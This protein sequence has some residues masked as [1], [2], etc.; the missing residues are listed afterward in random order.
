MIDA[1]EGRGMSATITRP[2]TVPR[3]HNGDR[4]TRAEFERRYEAM[5]D[6]K[7]AELIE[8]VVYMPSPVRWEQHGDQHSTLV[9][10]F[11]HY[12]LLTPGVEVGDNSTTRLDD[13]NE[14]Q[15]DVSLFVSPKMNSQVS[16]DDGYIEGA[17]EL[18]AEIAASTASIDL[19]DKLRAYQ[20]NGVREYLVW[21]VEDEEIDW[22]ILRDGTF[23]RG[24]PDPEGLLKLVAFPGLWLDVPALLRRDQSAA[25]A[26][27]TRGLASPEHAAFVERL[28]VTSPG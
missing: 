18:V 4:L 24:T 16:I 12:R 9:W 2:N 20:R 15:P 21:R 23:V 5:P 17:P 14:P 25:F 26:A 13:V 8:G 3:L 28:K 10:L 22:F 6:V 11:M 27:L 1:F 7:K 19:H